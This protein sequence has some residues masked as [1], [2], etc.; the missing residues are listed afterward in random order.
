MIDRFELTD[1]QIVLGKKMA[2]RFLCARRQDQ[3]GLWEEFSRSHHGGQAI[4]I[5]IAVRSYYF[6]ESILAGSVYTR[7]ASS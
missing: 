6:H 4:K 1:I 5:R 2:N 7:N 3:L